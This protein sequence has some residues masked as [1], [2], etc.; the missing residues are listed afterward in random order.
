MTDPTKPTAARR[1]IAAAV[2]AATLGIFSTLSFAQ[3]APPP[4]PPAHPAPPATRPAVPLQGTVTAYNFG[5]GGEPN[6][7]MLSTA[8]GKTVQVNFPPHA[9]DALA[10][11]AAVGADVKLTAA[12]TRSFPDH[13]V[14]ELASII[15]PDG[16]EMH[17]PK[18]GDEEAA[19][20]S[21]TVKRLNYARD[22]RVDGAVLD[23]GTFVQ[24]GPEGA[25]AADLSVGQPLSAE[26]HRR[27]AMSGQTVIEADSVNGTPVH[28]PAPPK[29]GGPH[30]GP[31]AGG[32]GD[33]PPPPRP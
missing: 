11:A 1:L 7:L 27:G 14:Y 20:V 2:A 18:P 30:H 17:V 23:D 31:H 12:P 4:P 15:G 6:G 25:E 8:G 9:A 22:G 13:P 21:G 24:S 5:P 10:N 29:P 33:P 26:G 3:P 16:H 28:H 32:P 19:K